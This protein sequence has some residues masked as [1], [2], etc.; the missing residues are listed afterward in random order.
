MRAYTAGLSGS[1]H[2]LVEGDSSSSDSSDSDSDDELTSASALVAKSVAK[3]SV[4]AVQVSK[5]VSI[6]SAL[7]LH[8]I[9]I[10]VTDNQGTVDSNKHKK[11]KHDHESTTSVQIASVPADNDPE[12]KKK[13]KK[14]DHN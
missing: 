7:N 5:P 8:Q 1:S 13:K 11:H 4:P 12:K 10:G 2:V 14:H 9:P 6:P 3:L